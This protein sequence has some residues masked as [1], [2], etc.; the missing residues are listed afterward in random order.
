[1]QPVQQEAALGL[2]RLVVARPQAWQPALCAAEGPRGAAAGLLSR[3]WRAG[4]AQPVL[5]AIRRGV[6][7]QSA[8][9]VG[10]RSPSAG[11]APN[12]SAL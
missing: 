2:L 7:Q 12:C 3:L 4:A 9:E 5:P 10:P 11:R 6:A 1:M 8:V